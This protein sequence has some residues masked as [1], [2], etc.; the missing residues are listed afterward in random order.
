MNCG[1]VHTVL[2]AELGDQIPLFRRYQHIV[3]SNEAWQEE[4]Q[5][6]G[7]VYCQRNADQEAN[8]AEIK[9]IPR[10]REHTC[11]NNLACRETRIGG[12]AVPGE[13]S[14]G[15]DDESHAR[16]DESSAPKDDGW[17]GES[18]GQRDRDHPLQDDG[19][20]KRNAKDGISCLPVASMCDFNGHRGY[21]PLH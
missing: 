6:P 15:K 19:N 13:L 20:K 4:D 14:A 3:A 1:G 10:D 18:L 21:H 8:H 17:T 7:Q 5:H 11:G 9:G 2:L 12:L 16:H